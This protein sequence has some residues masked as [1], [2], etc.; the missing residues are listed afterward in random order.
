MLI[1]RELEHWPLPNTLLISLEHTPASDVSPNH[2]PPDWHKTLSTGEITQFAQGNYR[3]GR[4]ASPVSQ[5]NQ[6]QRVSS[7]D[8]LPTVEMLPSQFYVQG[9]DREVAKAL[10]AGLG[11]AVLVSLSG[12]VSFYLSY[13]VILVHELGHSAL[14]WLFGFPAIPAFDFLHGGGVSVSSTD[15]YF[16]IVWLLYGG[17][18]WLLYR[19][20]RNTLTMQVLVTTGII[21]TIFAFSPIQDLL[22]VA[23]GHG[24]ELIF[25]GMFC[26]RG[27]SGFACRYSIE[28]PLYL[29]LGLFTSIYD[30]RFCWNL[31]FDPVSLDI[32]LQGKGGLIDNDLVRVARDH[33]NV[34]L[35]VVVWAF[36]LMV[37]AAPLISAGLYRYRQWM[38][39]AFL[40]LFYVLKD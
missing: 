31:L 7:E 3:G 16:A 29:M 5:G 24:F 35:T 28:R 8:L 37:A 6:Y 32:Y 20:R 11:L 15:R 23:M 21:Y 13:F 33:L 14:S 19:Y 38:I 2:L 36:L 26:Y 17:L 27:L 30:L 25:A 1:C 12:Q 34:P 4:S 22:R 40:R 10:V 18:G 9:F 39:A